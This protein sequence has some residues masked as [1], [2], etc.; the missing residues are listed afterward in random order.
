VSYKKHNMSKT[1]VYHTW[2]LMMN[3]CHNKKDSSYFKYGARGI[4]VCEKWKTFEN[5]LEDMGLPLAHESIDRID[6]NGNYSPENCRWATRKEQ[7][8]NRR[9]NRIYTLNGKSK[10]LKEWSE[11]YK[12][13]Y[14]TLHN[15]VHTQ[16]WPIMRAL[17]TKP[18]PGGHYAS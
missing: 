15:R 1:K 2:V 10:T 8:R 9:S 12:I 13:N 3:R 17:T 11:I 4:S 14:Q 7:C 5:F 16:K 6:N 18:K